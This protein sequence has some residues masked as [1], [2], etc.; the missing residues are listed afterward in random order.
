[1]SCW[2]Q[3]KVAWTRNVLT[4][5][6]IKKITQLTFAPLVP[7]DPGSPCSIPKRK[8]IKEGKAAPAHPSEPACFVS[9]WRH[10]ERIGT[11]TCGYGPTKVVVCRSA[12][13]VCVCVC[14]LV[15]FCSA[16]FTFG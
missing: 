11:N 4:S 6:L 15:S 9:T 13:C 5:N 3:I 14:T 1:M 16:E 10:V 8:P 2:Q 7:S 12:E